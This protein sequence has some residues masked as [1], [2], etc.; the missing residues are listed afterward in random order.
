MVAAACACMQHP[1]QTRLL[2]PHEPK[3]WI[4]RLCSGSSTSTAHREG[5]SITAVC[6]L[7]AA[8]QRS[9]AAPSPCM[10]DILCFGGELRTWLD[11]SDDPCCPVLFSSLC[12]APK[13]YAPEEPEWCPLGTPGLSACPIG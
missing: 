7:R 1:A 8:K 4:A 10:W 5:R 6:S 2:S 13:E 12:S 3:P 9:Q 11:T